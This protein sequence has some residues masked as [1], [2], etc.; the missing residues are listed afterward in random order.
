MAD[1]LADIGRYCLVYVMSVVCIFWLIIGGASIWYF[2][3]CPR[4]DKFDPN[5]SSLSPSHPRNL[6]QLQTSIES[7]RNLL[8]PQS[9]TESEEPA[10]NLFQAQ[11]STESKASET[12]LLHV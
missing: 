8:E 11:S 5:L 7:G 4:R 9:S 3:L 1:I 12:T 2:C 6:L 10:R